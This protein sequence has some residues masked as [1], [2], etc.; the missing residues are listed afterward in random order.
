MNWLIPPS[1]GLIDGVKTMKKIEAII[2][3]ERL[4]ALKDALMA[5]RVDGITISQVHGC[6]KQHGWTEHIRGNE[7][8]MN[9]RPKVEIKIVT[10]DLRVEEIISI[11]VGT[12]RT[13]EVGDGKIFVTDVADCVRIRTGERGENAV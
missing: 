11:I 12:A 7:V 9:V 8:L 13:G 1:A 6:G 5:A 3:P 10:A 2:R 4:E